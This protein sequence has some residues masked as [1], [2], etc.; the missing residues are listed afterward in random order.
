MALRGYM[1]RFSQAIAEGG[2]GPC[3]TGL[4]LCN[5][6]SQGGIGLCI[7]RMTEPVGNI[8]TEE[9]DE[10]VERLQEKYR[11]NDCI[12]CWTSCR[13]A[14]ETLLYGEDRLMNL[15]DYYGLVKPMPL[16]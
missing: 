10:L 1:A 11:Q 9:M 6:D 8:L 4:N 15:W 7:D 14:I 2:I 3:R 12:R 13:G 5:I 16:S